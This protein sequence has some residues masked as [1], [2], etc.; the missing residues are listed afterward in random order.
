MDFSRLFFRDPEDTPMRSTA[1]QSAVRLRLAA[2]GA[3]TLAVC[4]LPGCIVGD[5]HDEMVRSNDQLLRSNDQL[6]TLNETLRKLE[7][8]DAKLQ[9]VDDR[10]AAVDKSLERVDTSLDRVDTS[11]ADGEDKLVRL[12]TAAG[13]TN[14]KMAIIETSLRDIDAHLST[15][16]GTLGALD[17]INPFASRPKV[18]DKPEA[19]TPPEEEPA[20]T[21]ADEI[22]PNAAAGE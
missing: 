20:R 14:D 17:A 21:D 7:A 3:S 2:L 4:A 16:D 10:L 12:T 5:I 22:D 11:I 19:E 8:I 18:E 1:P 6:V 9:M 13:A 15:I